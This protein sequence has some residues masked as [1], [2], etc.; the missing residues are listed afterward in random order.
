MRKLKSVL[1]EPFQDLRLFIEDI[2]TCCS[3]KRTGGNKKLQLKYSETGFQGP[4][5][6][7]TYSLSHCHG[8]LRHL[9]KT[10]PFLMLS[11]TPMPFFI[12]S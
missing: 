4:G 7:H 9:T 12:T 3:R 1:V 5:F 8:V 6:V 10:E 11:Q 2:L